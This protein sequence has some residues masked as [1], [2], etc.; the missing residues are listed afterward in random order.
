MVSTRKV[1]IQGGE[2]HRSQLDSGGQSAGPDGGGRMREDI[3]MEMFTWK[4][5]C[6]LY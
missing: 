4:C 2:L 3:V 5:M 1:D 6:D